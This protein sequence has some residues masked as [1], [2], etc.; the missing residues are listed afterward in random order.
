MSSIIKT[1]NVRA[2]NTRKYFLSTATFVFD[3]HANDMDHNPFILFKRE[4]RER[5]RDVRYGTEFKY[6]ITRVSIYLV[7]L[8]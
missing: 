2:K 6:E 8:C 3:S 5:E 7:N 1:S 4:K